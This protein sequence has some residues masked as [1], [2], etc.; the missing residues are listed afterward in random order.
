MDKTVKIALDTVQNIGHVPSTF[1]LLYTQKAVRFATND[2]FAKISSGP[3][4]RR[5]DPSPQFT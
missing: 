1:L 3:S 2:C 5:A 4:T